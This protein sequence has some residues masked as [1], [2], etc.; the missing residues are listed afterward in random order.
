MYIS[1]D[2]FHYHSGSLLSSSKWQEQVILKIAS[3]KVLKILIKTGRN[4]YN[5]NCMLIH[6]LKR[7]ATFVSGWLFYSLCFHPRNPLRYGP[8]PLINFMLLFTT[9][10]DSDNILDLHALDELSNGLTHLNTS[11]KLTPISIL[12]NI[13]FTKS[14][15]QKSLNGLL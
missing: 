6:R 7:Y 2:T 9:C 13:S 15:L 1:L 14:L 11:N 4:K 8:I 12:L 10:L 5:T 3:S